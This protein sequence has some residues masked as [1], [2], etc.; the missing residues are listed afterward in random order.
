MTVQHLLRELSSGATL[1]QI[2][3]YCA[4]PD[5]AGAPMLQL[6][7]VYRLEDPTEYFTTNI[8][9]R[10]ERLLTRSA[11]TTA[12]K[13]IP[14][15]EGG[16]G[17]GGF[18]GGGKNAKRAGETESPQYPPR[19]S[20]IGTP[21]KKE[22][23]T[24]SLTHRPKSPGGTYLC[25]DHGSWH[26]CSRKGEACAHSHKAFPKADALDYTIRMQANRRGGLKSQ[27]KLTKGEAADKLNGSLRQK[28]ETE[29]AAKRSDKHAGGFDESPPEELTGL[30]LTD[31]E[32]DLRRILQGPDSQWLEDGGLGAKATPV[33]TTEPAD[34]QESKR[35]L[36]MESIDSSEPLA[37]TEDGLFGMHLR[38]R[39]KVGHEEGQRLC[40]QEV[41]EHAVN[42]GCPE[43]ATQADTF[44]RKHYPD[45][46]GS[47]EVANGAVLSGVKHRGDDLPAIGVLTW[48]GVSWE[49]WITMTCSRSTRS[50]KRNSTAKRAK[51]ETLASRR[52][53][54]FCY[55]WPPVWPATRAT[56]SRRGNRY[57]TKPYR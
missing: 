33:Q 39:L 10:H 29:D 5:A 46:A 53:N 41:A 35:A 43:L 21:M 11:W 17:G 22:K 34:D 19:P 9:A 48:A 15:G 47:T 30:G 49:M 42:F 32:D 31:M 23:V 28:H 54:V 13:Q 24:R 2:R 4:A 38:N 8:K 1:E 3:F 50:S 57:R 45:K 40:I 27:Q 14:D 7:K 16:G 12:F 55:M 26:G 25:W 52:A 18:G 56:V 51:M 20:L 36:A 44:L 6:P 37:A